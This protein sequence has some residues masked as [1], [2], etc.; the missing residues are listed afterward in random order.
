MAATYLNINHDTTLQ[1]RV[2]SKYISLLEPTEVPLLQKLGLDTNPLQL[3]TPIVTGRKFEWHEDT[4][5]SLVD[6]LNGAILVGATTMVVD[7]ATKF[8]V[9]HILEIESEYVNVTAVDTTAQTLTVSRAWGGTSAAAHADNTVVTA[10]GIAKMQMA[11]YSLGALTT[12][13]NLYNYPQ[14]IEEGFQYNKAFDDS[15]K[16]DYGV[17]SYAD[18]HMG[19]LI[20]GPSQIGAKGRAGILA[21]A[22]A[23]IAYYGKRQEPTGITVAAGAGGM[24]HFITTNLTG[25]TST[26]LS[27]TSIETQAAA[28]YDAGG[29]PDLLVV[30]TAAKRRISAWA[31]GYIRTT[32]GET[33]IGN[34]ISVIDT[35]VVEGIQ[36]MVDRFCPS[37]KAYLLDTTRL[38]YVT[39]RP[40]EVY[41]MPTFSP[42]VVAKS[43]LGEYS[44][45]VCNEEA[46]AIITHDG[47]A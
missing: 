2:V 45:W 32:R 24:A 9:G 25:D 30:G 3:D 31:D 4:L 29:M 46:H 39:V 11:N 21:I 18:Y 40:F 26:P 23:K 41:D 44:F 7:D 47:T 20:G 17:S 1:R 37:T 35:P 6:A 13:S 42:D 36:I 43:V 14:I 8:H 12:T 27:R 16:N 15:A 5:P 19:K 34:A 22:L 38:G 28:I 33:T 10:R